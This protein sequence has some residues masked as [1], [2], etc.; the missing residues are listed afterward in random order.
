[1]AGGLHAAAGDWPL[2]MPQLLLDVCIC[3]S[4]RDMLDILC[5][6]RPAVV[7]RIQWYDMGKRPVLWSTHDSVYTMAMVACGVPNF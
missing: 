5:V 2:K 7:W 1:M 6:E 3:D 4:C